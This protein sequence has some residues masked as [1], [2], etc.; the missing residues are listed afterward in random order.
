MKQFGIYALQDLLRDFY[1]SEIAN[2]FKIDEN[3][4]RYINNQQIFID[5]KPLDSFLPV[6]N[7]SKKQIFC[8]A[9]NRVLKYLN[10]FKCSKNDD[11]QDFLHSEE[12]VISMQ[13]QSLTRTYLIIDNENDDNIAAYFAI[14]LKPVI[15]KKN[16]KMSK[17]K[18][19]RIRFFTHKNEE[20][21]DEIEIILAY[22]I[23]QIGRSDIYKSSDINLEKI[24]EF[25]FGVINKIREYIG[26]RT[27]L[28]EVNNEEK[29]VELYEKHGFEFIQFENDLSQLMQWVYHY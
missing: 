28:V 13:K 14:S 24:L 2:T 18:K 19:K 9:E 6:G 10:T 29:L 5:S 3:D 23:G 1:I 15:L 8:N 16:N 12:K 4:I 21:E 17:T 26:G 22:L 25:I 27:I 11:V 7:I 20:N